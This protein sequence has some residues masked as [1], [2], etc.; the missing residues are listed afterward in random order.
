H[1]KYIAVPAGLN[2]ATPQVLP[3]QPL[4]QL[5]AGASET[6]G[7]LNVSEQQPIAKS[8][9]GRAEARERLAERGVREGKA[10]LV[11]FFAGQRERVV[12]KVRAFPSKAARLK[13]LPPDWWDDAYEDVQLRTALQG[14]YLTIGRDSLQIVADQID[15]IVVTKSVRRILSDLLEYGGARIT[16]INDR[17]RD[18][19][20][21]E[22]TEG[23]RRGYSLD[24]LIDGVPAESFA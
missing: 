13:A 9:K 16:D 17:T 24:Q 21:A 14:L 2:P 7:R 5:T 15:R 11:R 23:V 10:A 22:L 4:P 18:A 8:T 6:R 12:A 1:I 20:K 3:A 19:I